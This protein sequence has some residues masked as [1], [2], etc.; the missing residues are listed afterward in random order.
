VATVTG[1]VAQIKVAPRQVVTGNS[2]AIVVLNDQ[3]TNTTE[4][5]VLWVHLVNEFVP[6]ALA[7]A[8]VSSLSLLRDALV[9]KLPVTIVTPSPTNNKVQSVA[10]PP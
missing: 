9:N 10:V 6:T 8:E 4:T 1:T 2:T 3:A 7:I 5:F